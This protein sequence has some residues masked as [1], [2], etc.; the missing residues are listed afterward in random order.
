MVLNPAVPVL[1][2]YK[3]EE[4]LPRHQPEKGRAGKLNIK[5]CRPSEKRD[6]QWLKM[7]ECM[8]RIER[9]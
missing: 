5:G 9:S 2:G 1:A 6:N 7:H 3:R 4:H 8:A